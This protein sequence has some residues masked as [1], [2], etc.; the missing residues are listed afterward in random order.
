M[1]SMAEN[2]RRLKVDFLCID[3][4]MALTFSSIALNTRDLQRRERTTRAARRA[5]D[6]IQ[7]LKSGVSMTVVDTE[8]LNKN[9]RRLKN[10]LERLGENF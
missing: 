7:K 4:Q 3:A 8:K 1:L 6:T 2:T 9:L 10:E 5:Y